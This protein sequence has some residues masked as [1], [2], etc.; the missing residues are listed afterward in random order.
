MSDAV[1]DRWRLYC[2]VNAFRR[3]LRSKEDVAGRI[4]DCMAA[5]CLIRWQS[6][7]SRN[8]SRNV[9]IPMPISAVFI[10]RFN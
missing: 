5:R 4:D 6:L 1:A 9:Q 10:I 3:G 2:H 8:Q 7:C